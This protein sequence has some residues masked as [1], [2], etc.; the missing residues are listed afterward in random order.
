MKKDIHTLTKGVKYVGRKMDRNVRFHNSKGGIF[1]ISS[2][3]LCK[4]RSYVQNSSQKKEAGGVLLGRYIIDSDDV[5]VDIITVPMKGDRRSK[6]RFFRCARR[7][8][9]VID[10]VWEASRH[11]CNYLGGWHTHS[12]PIPNMSPID[13]R[14]WKKALKE[15][16]FDNDVLYFVIVGTHEIRVWEGRKRNGIITQFARIMG[17][18]S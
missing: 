7:H 10:A 8:Q 13:Q 12:E 2:K 6:Q 16:E 18:E 15:E 4:M 1:C 9:A 14:D 11:R 17:K 5:M 3:A